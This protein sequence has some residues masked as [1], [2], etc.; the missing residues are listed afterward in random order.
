MTMI[1]KY[2]LPVGNHI[3]LML[4][5]GTKILSV[6]RQKQ[7][8]YIWAMEPT[9]EMESRNFRV[10]GT[11]QPLNDIDIAHLIHLGTVHFRESSLVWH[12]FEEVVSF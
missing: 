11:G 12:V 3:T 6:G 9:G 8:L 10:I 4:P 1:C 5:R 2:E 7:G